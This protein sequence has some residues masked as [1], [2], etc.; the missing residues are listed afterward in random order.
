M[1]RGDTAEEAADAVEDHMR[2]DHPE[3]SG[4]VRREDLLE[5][6]EEA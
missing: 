6:V 3:L 2:D 1:A 5:M 4:K